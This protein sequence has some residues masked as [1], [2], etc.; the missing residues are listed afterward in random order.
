MKQQQWPSFGK[1]KCLINKIEKTKDKDG[2]R[3]GL[4]LSVEVQCENPRSFYQFY[5]NKYNEEESYEA[6]KHIFEAI[7]NPKIVKKLSEG[8]NFL[9]F[10]DEAFDMLPE[11]LDTEFDVFL[12]YQWNYPKNNDGVEYDKTYLQLPKSVKKGK[13][14]C[15]ATKGYRWN[16]LEQFTDKDDEV[17]TYVDKEGNL[18]PFVRD[19]WFM[20]SNWGT[21]QKK[22]ED[23]DKPKA[24]TE[25]RAKG[26][27][28]AE[29]KP[30]VEADD[31]LP[32]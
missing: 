13:F 1:N 11:K 2:H 31:D 26:K 14:L 29:P 18:H 30:V 16:K 21:Q 7:L 28:K 20:L 4:F 3:N 15:P 22:N 24:E 25:Y 19:G 12:Q 10:I 9:D 32:F 5:T 27:A 6:V 23:E 17:L 8:R